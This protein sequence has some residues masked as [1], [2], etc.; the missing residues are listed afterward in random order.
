MDQNNKPHYPMEFENHTKMSALMLYM[1]KPIHNTGEIVTIDSGFCVAAG[2]LE[3]HH[4]GVYGQAL[5]KKRGWYW[6]KHVPG[7]EIEEY[8][9]DKELGHVET[10]KQC[11]YRKDFLV[12]YQKDSDYVTKIMSTHGL[13]VQED[14]TTYCFINGE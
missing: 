11:I 1:T 14:H 8:M 6:P 9:K 12:L 3:L 4:V 7:N 2:I 10:Y 5:I 13:V